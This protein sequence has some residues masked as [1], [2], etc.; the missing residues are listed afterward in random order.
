MG[1]IVKRWLNRSLSKQNLEHTLEQQPAI[2]Q[3]RPKGIRMK[4]R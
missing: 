4:S 3:N 2:E 1:L